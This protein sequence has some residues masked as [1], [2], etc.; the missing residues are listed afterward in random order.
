MRTYITLFL[1]LCLGV[2]QAQETYKGAFETADWTRIWTNYSPNTADYPDTDIELSGVITTDKVLSNK[3]VYLLKGSVYVTSGATLTIE[4]GTIIKGD[5]ESN[6]TLIISQGAK[7]QANGTQT[8][9]IIFTSNQI[10]GNR[11][12]GDWG[13]IIILGKAPVSKIGGV[14]LLE[15]NFTKKYT[16]FGGKDVD[17][18]S[19]KLQYVRIECA[20]HQSVIDHGETVLK[21][22]GWLTTL[23]KQH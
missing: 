16:L 19:G 20:G 4:E 12:P 5:F 3:H 9:P 14:S 17:D 10:V 22:W 15:G 1:C 2:V 11:K 23:L 21:V 18:D 7:I 13:G 6:G 8:N